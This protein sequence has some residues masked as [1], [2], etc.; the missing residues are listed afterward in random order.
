M[1][2]QTATVTP[3]IEALLRLHLDYRENTGR[4]VW[5]IPRS[6]RTREGDDAGSMSS[7]GY[8]MVAMGSFKSTAARVAWFLKTGE[9]PQGRIFFRDEDATNLRWSNLTLDNPRDLHPYR[10]PVDDWTLDMWKRW[11]D[12][13]VTDAPEWFTPAGQRAKRMLEL[14]D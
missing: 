8:R 3:E 7:V 5:A 6:I 4:I 9:W 1:P 13:G 2:R 10:R 12:R 14:L 11:D